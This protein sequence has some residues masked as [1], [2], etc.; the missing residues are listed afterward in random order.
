MKIGALATYVPAWARGGTAV[1]GPDEDLVTMSVAAGRALCD[2]ADTPIQRAVIVTL[3][4]G[5]LE[6]A[7]TAVI[8]RGLGMDRTDWVE[9]RIGAAPAALDAL[10][11]AAPGTAVIAVDL[12][13]RGACG[14]AA[15]LAAGEG[16]NLERSGSALG[17]LPMRVK[18]VSAAGTAVYDDRRAERELGWV[19]VAR[20]FAPAA[21]H[22]LFLAGIPGADAT[23][24]GAA[25]V[26][27]VAAA[28]GA[29]A[30]LSVLAALAEDGRSGLLV[31]VDTATAVAAEVSGPSIPVVREARLPLDAARLP[32]P[33]SGPE[34]VI[35]FS[36]PAYER[37]FEAKI[38]LLASHCAC[39]AVEFPPRRFCAV[40]SRVDEIALEP[41]ARTGEIYSA[42][43]VHTPV[44]GMAGP[45]AVAVVAI[46][47]SD[48]R[49]LAPVTD[50][51]FGSFGIGSR[52]RL[53]LRLIAWREGVPDYGYAFQ[54]E[55]DEEVSR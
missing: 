10:L 6:G 1:A 7:A 43:T 11:S 26:K 32:R 35:P 28:L 55:T 12:P 18:H 38:G 17:S 29:A 49:V 41:L 45:Y 37:A 4:P 34:Q 14:A 25:A 39:G 22:D 52:G 13:E 40:C 16:L 44:P 36:M 33:P 20:E 27:N 47:D 21:G 19:P 23:R 53:I 5:L 50:A 54:P 8:A 24:L 15:A 9:L 31:A 3:D 42:V 51:T 30:P 2:V 46:D 48:I